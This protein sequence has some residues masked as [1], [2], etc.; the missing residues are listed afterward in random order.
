MA[1]RVN[2]LTPSGKERLEDELT[3]L[4]ER[5][6]AEIAERL[7]QAIEDGDLSE[8]AGYEEAKREQSFVEGR[9]REL[10]AILANAQI[11]EGGNGH[12]TVSA[13]NVVTVAEEGGQPET[14]HI[15][16]ILEADP[17]A[18]RISYESP[19][20]KALLGHAVGDRVEVRT[21]AGLLHFRILAIE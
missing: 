4:T 16:G 21:P 20:G 5:R 14:Y 3:D 15:V 9:I 8:N 19:L 18:G 17:S 2:I 11:L 6:R 13:G 12:S 1:D 10:R 7:R